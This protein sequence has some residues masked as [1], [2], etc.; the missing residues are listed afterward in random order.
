[1]A[2]RAGI[3]PASSVLETEVLPLYE[4]PM[5]VVDLWG[6]EP[7]VDTNPP[8]L[9]RLIYSQMAGKRSVIWWRNGES[10]PDF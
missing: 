4:R 6:F 9:Q 10:N 7:V 2:G 3:E 5:K 1:M 8:I